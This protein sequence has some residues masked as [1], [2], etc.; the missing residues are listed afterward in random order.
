VLAS[1]AWTQNPKDPNFL[2]VQGC[3]AGA[4]RSLDLDV[5]RVLGSIAL[6]SR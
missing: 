2:F 6:G 4:D 1:I 5:G 3:V